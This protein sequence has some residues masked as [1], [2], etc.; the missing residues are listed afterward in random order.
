ML[1][2][3]LVRFGF[4]ELNRGGGFWTRVWDDTWIEVRV[5]GDLAEITW[6]RVAKDE[7]ILE[8]VSF[9]LPELERDAVSEVRRLANAA[10]YYDRHGRIPLRIV[11]RGLQ[12][13][14]RRY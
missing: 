2:E 3:Q 9:E 14:G 4:E 10:D 11:P 5:L 8:V 13:M 12:G 7:D 1:E 6:F